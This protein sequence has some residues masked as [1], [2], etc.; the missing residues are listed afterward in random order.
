MKKRFTRILAALALLAF[1]AI[2]MGMRADEAQYVFNTDAG[3]AA[4][5]IEKPSAGA[6][7][8]LSTDPYTVGQISMSVTHASTP[9][10]VWNNNG[11]L[12]LRIY[13]N[14][15]SLTFA[16]A[17]GYTISG[18]TITGSKT[19]NFTVN[20]GTYSNGSWSNDTDGASS[21]TFTATNTGNINTITVTYSSGSIPSLDPSN[22]ALVD[23]PVELEFDL[24][25]NADAQTISYTTSSTGAITITGGTGIVTTDVN[26]NNKTIT[27]T[28]VAVTNGPQTIT[29]NQAAD[30]TYE[31]G[32]VTFTVDIED[33]TPSTG[34]DVTFDAT[35]DKDLNNTTQ[36]EGSIVKDGVTFTCND[37]ILGNGT[38]YRLYK[39]STTTFSVESGTITQIVFTCTSGNP[40]SGF[41]TQTGWTTNG[42]NGTWTG[43]ATSVSFVA[44]SKQVRATQIVVTV[45]GGATG[46]PTT[47]TINVPDGFNTDLAEGTEAGTL[48]ATVSANGEPITGATVT[49]ESSDTGIAEINATTGA[50]TLVAM[51]TTTITAS[52][53][54]VENT[55]LPSTKTYQL[56]VT[57][58]NVPGS[59]AHPYTVAQARAAID[60]NTGIT[61]VYA[62]GIVSDI[63][64]AYDSDWGNVTFDM[65]DASGDEDYLRAYR[66]GGEQAANVAVG[67]VVVVY[68]SMTLYTGA[69]PNIYEFNQGCQIVSLVPHQAQQYT[70]SVSPLANVEMFVFD[71]DDQTNPLIEGGSTEQTA[72]VLEGK[73]VLVSV[74]AASG[75]VLATFTVDGVDHL[76]EIQDDSYTF[77]M[78]T[79]DVTITATA[80]EYVAPTVDEY[81][82][83]NGALVEGD[84]VIYYDGSAM[85]NIVENSRLYYKT[86]TPN[87]DVIITD[88]ATIVWHIAPK[89]DY[90]TIYSADAE[91][92]AASTGAANKAQM[93]A[94]GNDDMALWT[95]SGTET[96]EFVNKKNAAN[97]VNAYLRNNKNAT[98][99]YG[100]ACYNPENVGGALSL[101]KKVEATPAGYPYTVNG[102]GT[103]AGGYVLMATPTVAN[104]D[105]ASVGMITDQLGASATPDNSTYDLYY[106]DQAQDKEWRNYR[107][108][109]FELVPGK[110]YLYASKND[111]T[112]NFT[113]ELNPSF[114]DVT[115]PYTEGDFTKSIYLAGNS[116]TEA[117]TFYVYDFDNDLELQTVNFLTINGTG[118][119]FTTATATSLTAQPMQGF[120]VQAAGSNWIL[121]TED[122]SDGTNSNQGV[123]LL[124]I[125]VLR[126]RGNVIDNA[127]VSFSNGS[128]M[129]KFYLRDNTTRVYIP[130]DNREMAVVRSAAEAE[131]PVSFRASENGTYTLAVEAENVEMNYL[132][133]IDN[134][135]GMDVDL[136]QTPSYT[137]EAKTSDY[138]SRFRL[139]FKANGTNENNAET[140]AYFNGTNWTVSNVGDATLQVVDVTGRTVANQ[141]INGNAE[142]NLNQPAG[143]YVIR[144]VNGDNVKTQ[145][146]VV[147]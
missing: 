64:T 11:T 39:N 84:Y 117:Q 22:L 74:S 99:N 124:N 26:T 105:P 55:Y 82:L 147:R 49:W 126:D 17:T 71:N 27:V 95:V 43:S 141:M 73:T 28:P 41:S 38:E 75:Y 79:H 130:Q 47:I 91:K 106:Y 88:D 123:S 9:T 110:G 34:T 20:V 67:D 37:G 89:G 2:P 10:R 7:T 87:D 90:W 132:H 29:V 33:S 83:Y 23:A 3:I 100:F 115:L 44:S 114:T 35:V 52:Y 36:G 129:N 92:Y 96:Y 120:F 140:F 59:Q 122:L 53:A 108:N 30:N 111:V 139:V 119:G 42:N 31:A 69:T 18:I 57:N 116:S 4:L 127:I 45:E 50:V 46:E 113:G 107:A 24:Y 15:G 94:D 51:G 142:L 134:L 12:D 101:Y 70:L 128:M 125:N 85:K 65:V 60:A 102:Y 109:D 136:L 66:C 146:V 93:L 76:S 145:K 81:E 133:L 86:V 98:N 80:T 48:T 131:M 1:L 14:G 144:L 54:G 61:N 40:A 21:V 118:D 25:D 58:S 97:N 104:A 135:T 6:G 121:S 8:S 62:T 56:V 77:V 112:L 72:Q 63:V 78:P 19:G 16:A 13:K 103:S 137:F 68:G 32:S 143:V 138:A 5:G